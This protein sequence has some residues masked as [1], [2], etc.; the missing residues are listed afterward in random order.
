MVRVCASLSTAHGP[1]MIVSRRPP[2]GHPPTITTV[3]GVLTSRLTSLY[4]LVTRIACW[5]PGRGSNSAGS[6]GP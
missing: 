2:T 5:T 6:I 4:G 3:S 1:A